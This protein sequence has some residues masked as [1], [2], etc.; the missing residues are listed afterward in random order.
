METLHPPALEKGTVHTSC[1]PSIND[2]FLAKECQTEGKYVLQTKCT[3]G[4]SSRGVYF[5]VCEPCFEEITVFACC[6][7]LTLR[8]KLRRQIPSYMEVD[9]NCAEKRSRHQNLTHALGSLGFYTSEKA[10]LCV[11]FGTNPTKSFSAL[12]YTIYIDTNF[13]HMY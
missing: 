10:Q 13:V 7:A 5:N 6:V 12:Q 9:N 11:Y 4:T 8:S 3:V 1:F 2:C